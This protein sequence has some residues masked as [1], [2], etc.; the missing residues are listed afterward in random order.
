MIDNNILLIEQSIVGCLLK[1]PTVYK[2]FNNDT[3][4]P[5]AMLKDLF[6]DEICKA[7]IEFTF[8]D[9]YGDSIDKLLLLDYLSDRKIPNYEGVKTLDILYL[10]AGDSQRFNTYLET[11][12]KRSLKS[13]LKETINLMQANL[14]DYDSRP[15]S[16]IMEFKN[17]L[18]KLSE[19]SDTTPVEPIS[20]TLQPFMETLKSRM[21]K[22]GNGFGLFTGN[23]SFDRL[24]NG[25]Q[26]G[27]LIIIGGRPAMGK[28][29][30]MLNW[31]WNMVNDFNYK[32]AYFTLEMSKTQLTERFIG[33]ASEI[34][35]SQLKSGV[36]GVEDFGRLS[37]LVESI[38][39]IPF[40]IVDIMYCELF[41]LLESART[42]VKR[43]GVNILFIDYLQLIRF[44]IGRNTNREAEVALVMRKLKELA[45]ELNVPVIVTSQLSRAVESR[46]GDKRPQLS[47]LRESGSI[48]QDADKVVFLYRA[49]YY[50]I[51]E[52]ANGQPTENVAELIIAKNRTGPTENVQIQF[53]AK[54]GRFYNMGE[55]NLIPFPRIRNDEFDAPF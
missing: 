9:G 13:K 22:E 34:S 16:L 19:I 18:N 11:L 3:H 1:D 43:D 46:G 6:S 25:F 55:G 2:A 45:R 51:T 38:K 15:Q 21:A 30:L 24:T 53:N 27:E 28:T 17:E 47:D 31:A 7:I 20:I 40:Y 52:D 12:H 5:K 48:E 10:R 41:D 29:A 42:A 35:T 50:D 44:K 39:E 23:V 36:L 8:K 26:P 32:V 49:E 33:M 37:K 54:V 14:E 4:F